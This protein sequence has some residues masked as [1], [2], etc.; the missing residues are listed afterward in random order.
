MGVAA[1]DPGVTRFFVL[2]A[3]VAAGPAGDD[4]AA[5]ARQGERWRRGGRRP[6]SSIRL[7]AGVDR[8]SAA[9]RGGAARRDPRPPSRPG[10]PARAAARPRRR[11]RRGRGRRPRRA[12]RR[13][14]ARGPRP[15]PR[16]GR[17]RGP[18]GR[19][20]AASSCWRS[21][22]CPAARIAHSLGVAAVAAALTAALNE[23]GQ[24]LCAPLVTAGAL[25]HDIARDAAAARR[26]RRRP[27]GAPG[28]PARRRRRAPAHAASASAPATSWTRRRS[29]T[30]P[31]SSSR[32]SRVVGLDARFAVRLE[33]YAG[34]EAALAGVRARKEEARAGAAARG[35]DPGGAGGRGASGAPAP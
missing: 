16:A 4:R 28:L 6:R 21:R 19:G 33:R 24:H 7:C 31:T 26:R 3:D 5:G 2:P 12:A 25:L 18:A 29:S 32:A 27:A 8:P 10:G 13:G 34:D 35:A 30:S 14:H 17:G 20:A 1:L 11:V 9:A 23:R 15:H 22:A